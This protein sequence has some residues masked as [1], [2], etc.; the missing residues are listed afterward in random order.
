VKRPHETLTSEEKHLILAK[1][2]MR[3]DEK[4]IVSPRH[5]SNYRCEQEI[6]PGRGLAQS[7]KKLCRETIR[8]IRHKYGYHY[9]DSVPMSSIDA[10]ARWRRVQFCHEHLH[11]SDSLHALSEPNSVEG[12]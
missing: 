2:L 11:Q 8:K 5:Y 7:S 1:K 9:Y 10:A 12:N 4:Q 3:K 6:V